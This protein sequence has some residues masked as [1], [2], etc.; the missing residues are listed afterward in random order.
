MMAFHGIAGLATG[1][2]QF[3]APSPAVWTQFQQLFTL[4]V[5]MFV[6]SFAALALAKVARILPIPVGGIG[7]VLF[8]LAFQVTVMIWVLA[9]DWDGMAAGFEVLHSLVYSMKMYSYLS[10]N[11]T[12]ETNHRKQKKLAEMEVEDDNVSQALSI[13][14]EEQKWEEEAKLPKNYPQNLT[15]AN[16][17]DYLLI[18]TLVYE[19]RYPRTEKIR[20]LYVLEKL[21][22]TIFT[23]ILL[24]VNTTSFS[25]VS[26]NDKCIFS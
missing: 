9:G 5:T 25:K 16:Y 23:M 8:I 21:I 6:T 1:S 12:W 19:A 24:H 22:A 7:R 26:A 3:S 17:L 15:I 2:I 13:E 18:P 4:E 20:P 10:M 11:E 14:D